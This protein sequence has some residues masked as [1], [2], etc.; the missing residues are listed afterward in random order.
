MLICSSSAEGAERSLG[1]WVPSR[2]A[3]EHCVS[4]V[5]THDSEVFDP[6]QDGSLDLS[7]HNV[8]SISDRSM[9]IELLTFKQPT[10]PKDLQCVTR[11]VA[12][13]RASQLRMKSVAEPRVSCRQS[14]FVCLSAST[15]R[16]NI[17]PNEHPV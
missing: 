16:Y 8:V 11:H 14:R 15:Y 5:D 3:Y 6:V 13:L 7:R 17:L 2:L 1:S 12:L 10:L 9:A 4:A